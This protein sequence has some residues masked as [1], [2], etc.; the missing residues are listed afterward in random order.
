[1]P[2]HE[3]TEI[4]LDARLAERDLESRDAPDSA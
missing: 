3:E 2:G 4:R 1:M